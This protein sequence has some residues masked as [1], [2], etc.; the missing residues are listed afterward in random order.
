M[1]KISS[2]LMILITSTCI[3]AQQYAIDKGAVIMSGTT[4]FSSYGGDLYERSGDRMTTLTIAPALNKFVGKNIFIG[5]ALAYSKMS[6]GDNSSTTLGVGPTIGY[7][8][9]DAKSTNYPF[10]GVGIS[11]YSV[12]DEDDSTGGH[13]IK[14]SS[15]I[16]ISSH[17][18]IGIIIEAGYHMMSLESTKGDI[19]TIGLGIA[20]LLF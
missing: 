17:K 7:A 12:G 2:F 13:D 10:L 19:I 6:R 15:G 9:G 3:F 20:G 8:I 16:I 4:T 18:H 11:Y 14:L 1:K 5:A